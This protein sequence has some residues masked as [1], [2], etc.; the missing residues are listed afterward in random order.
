V[1]AIIGLKAAIALLL[2]L[3]AGV[4][5]GRVLLP[6]DPG[7]LPRRALPSVRDDTAA[8]RLRHVDTRVP[9]LPAKKPES[10]TSA[11]NTTSTAT[12]PNA[13]SSTG[14]FNASPTASSPSSSS[15]TGDSRPHGV[16][17]GP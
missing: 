8:M 15:S 6:S 10:A 16:S 13:V 1:P 17:I 12:S 7:P 2:L 5:L 9:R 3:A 11:T 14:S 4:V